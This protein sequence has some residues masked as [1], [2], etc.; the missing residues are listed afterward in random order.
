MWCPTHRRA[1]DDDSDSDED[2]G[3]P[4]PPP[5]QRAAL[6]AAGGRPT[7]QQQQQ[8]LSA[9]LQAAFKQQLSGAGGG[10]GGANGAVGGLGAA[11][12]DPDAQARALAALAGSLLVLPGAS[13]NAPMVLGM[14]GGQG[15]QT[16]SA[17][18]RA[19]AAAAMAG[20]GAL[21]GGLGQQQQDA[22]GPGGLGQGQQQ[23]S[24]SLM[25][26]GGGPGGM[27]DSAGGSAGQHQLMMG[28]Q[29]GPMDAALQGDGR[30]GPRTILN[31]GAGGPG[32]GL[33]G[34]GG[35]GA[36]GGLGGGGG[37]AGSAPSLFHER[38]SASGLD[39]AS[40]GMP[41]H[42]GSNTS[43]GGGG[44][45][46][47]LGLGM[48]HG[49]GAQQF[50]FQQQQEPHGSAGPHGGA[51]KPV[52]DLTPHGFSGP[53]AQQMQQPS[54]V[55]NPFNAAGLGQGHVGGQATVLTLG[56]GH[57]LD[58]QDAKP[59]PGLGARG[60]QQQG[61]WGQGM[62]VKGEPGLDLSGAA[63]GRMGPGMQ[64]QH[65]QQHGGGGGGM[66]LN[67]G[68]VTPAAGQMVVD[69]DAAVH[70]HTEAAAADPM[71]GADCR[72]HLQLGPLLQEGDGGSA[73]PRSST[74]QGRQEPH[75]SAVRCSGL[76]LPPLDGQ[77]GVVGWGSPT[78]ESV[79]RC[80]LPGSGSD[81]D[82][83]WDMSQGSGSRLS[84]CRTDGAPEAGSGP[85]DRQ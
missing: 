19:T 30:P 13:G 48:Q 44:P 27:D 38:D 60:F 74:L 68:G 11:G 23:Q 7:T 58:L 77:A 85:V 33:M 57:E 63:M 78:S 80:T 12:G 39:S 66:V 25:L 9:V 41:G 70:A 20:K 36:L 15:N 28:Q 61:A 56:G 84:P 53:G 10:P 76:A 14:L 72:Q 55:P 3:A 45:G 67:L 47:A 21:P 73:G 40:G 6:P 17:L 29:G 22:A 32:G 34:G 8:Q 50:Q 5:A 2:F 69:G 46:G 75:S 4:Y 24:Q 59:L 62:H 16:A 51:P 71:H 54:H 1:R 64:Q 82:C 37:M 35:S 52:L 81:N 42:R 31:L 18:L 79:G 83:W 65:Q 26:G 49:G 43:L